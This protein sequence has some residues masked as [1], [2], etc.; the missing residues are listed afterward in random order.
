M[1]CSVLRRVTLKEGLLLTALCTTTMATT[2]AI[3]GALYGA[4]LATIL[5]WARI[6]R[7]ST[8]TRW[9]QAALA[10]T[11]FAGVYVWVVLEWVVPHWSELGVL[12]RIGGVVTTVAAVAGCVLVVRILLAYYQNR[13]PGRGARAK[14]VVGA[15]IA[16]SFAAAQGIDHFVLVGL[17][18]YVHA[19]LG[20]FALAVA[21]LLAVSLLRAI[22]TASRARRIERAMLVVAGLGVCGSVAF[23]AAGGWSP[24]VQRTTVTEQARRGLSRGLDRDGDGFGSILR[25][26]DCDDSNPAVSPVAF[27]VPGNGIDDNCAAGDA[28]WPPPEPPAETTSVKKPGYNV[29]VFTI[30]ATR[31]DHVGAY[32]YARN[33]TPNLDRLARDALVFKRAYSQSTKTFFSMPS[34]LFGRYLSNLPR[35]YADPILREQKGYLFRIPPDL[36]SL[37]EV[38]RDAGYRTAAFTHIRQTYLQGLDRGLDVGEK[39]GDPTRAALSLL[40]EWRRDRFFLWLHYTEPH[41]AYWKHSGFEFGDQDLDRYDSE[42]AFCDAELGKIVQ[43]LERKKL[44]QRTILVVASDHGE[45]FRE[46]G[47][48]YHGP[49]L[50][51]EVL[52]VPLVVRIPGGPKGEVDTIVELVD[53]MPTLLDILNVPGTARYLDGTNLLAARYRTKSRPAYSEYLQRHRSMN[54]SWVTDRYK[55]IIAALKGSVELYDLVEDPAESFNLAHELPDVLAALQEQADLRPLAGHVSILGRTRSA[56]RL[57][58][59]LVY[60]QRNGVLLQALDR[61]HAPVP[62]P[63]RWFLEEVAQREYLD[64]PVLRRLTELGVAVH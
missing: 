18:E 15:F 57:A 17:Y 55:L 38:L 33:T 22:G 1:T 56:D 29:L 11:P 44:Y 31:A 28:P 46:H 35:D 10:G 4:W 12:A 37:P 5:R 8:L 51:N 7:R 39:V 40:R 43:W 62:E 16:G 42:I 54:R 21:G 53:V 27:E 41:A 19:G 45:E 63:S 58:E 52:H 47:G 2:G 20:V 64:E 36:P 60:L 24:Y 9:L 59:D 14:W 13:R 32:G 50:Y 25:G 34:M 48:Q 26:G 6:R 61:F 23:E 30:D 3:T 49:A